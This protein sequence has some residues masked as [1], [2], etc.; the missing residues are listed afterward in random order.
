MESAARSN[1]EGC[2]LITMFLREADEGP[3]FAKDLGAV[4]IR[5]RRRIAFKDDGGD[6]LLV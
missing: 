2:G 6:G 5:E 1:L 3:K 4:K